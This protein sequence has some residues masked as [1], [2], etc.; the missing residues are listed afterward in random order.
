MAS[1]IDNI[2]NLFSLQPSAGTE[3]QAVVFRRN[4][5][6]VTDTICITS[7]A[8]VSNEVCRI[9]SALFPQASTAH[10]AQAFIDFE[11]IHAGKYDSY[12]A[13]ETPYHDMQHALDVV[14][15]MARILSGYN[16]AE[17]ESRKIAADLAEIGIIVALFCDVGYIRKHDD[18][19]IEHGA[20]FTSTHVSRGAEFLGLYLHD[21][22][23]DAQVELAK[24]L[25]HFTGYE[26]EI[27]NIQSESH[28]HKILGYMIGSADLVAQLADCC[29]LEKCSERLYEEFV[30][31]E[32]V[33]PEYG[34]DSNKEYVFESKDHMMKM[35]TNFM[36]F[37]IDVRLEKTL[38][39][40][41]HYLS[42][43]FDGDNPYLDFMHK[44]KTYLEK[45]LIKGGWKGS[46]R[47]ALP[48]II[49]K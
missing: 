40:V 27:E 30:Y 43:F 24:K 39:G 46:L 42:T 33:R 6:D 8:A 31:A 13:A 48:I 16:Q 37:S 23:L 26:V 45:L 2:F 49:K 41:Y 15:C 14:L 35:T 25:I 17:L 18:Y 3:A 10:L 47:R 29:Y 5:Y 38:G 34:G 4:D 7:A 32:L 28:Q 21:L 20:V 19:F 9:Y 11:R 12:Y 1:L 36:K 22:E 44:N